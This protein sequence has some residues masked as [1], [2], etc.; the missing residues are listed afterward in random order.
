MLE[1]IQI[2]VLDAAAVTVGRAFTV[3]VTKATL[4]LVQPAVLVPTTEYVAV[5]VGLNAT[6]LE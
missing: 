3:T 6:L 1:P 4:V 2:K 5:V